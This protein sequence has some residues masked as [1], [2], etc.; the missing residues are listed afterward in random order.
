M[1]VVQGNRPANMALAQLGAGQQNF[2]FLRLTQLQL[3]A[4]SGINPP[5]APSY[6]LSAAGY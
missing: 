4:D 2:D 6:A 1:G 3:W 5:A